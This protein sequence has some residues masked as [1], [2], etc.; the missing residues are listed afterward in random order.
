MREVEVLSLRDYVS[1][2]QYMAELY[3]KVRVHV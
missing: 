3:W 1:E 2:A